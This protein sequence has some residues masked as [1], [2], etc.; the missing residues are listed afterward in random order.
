MFC[1]YTH[2]NIYIII[3][4]CWQQAYGVLLNLATTSCSWS[5]KRT[6]CHTIATATLVKVP[7]YD[8]PEWPE[9]C[10]ADTLLD[11]VALTPKVKTGETGRMPS[12]FKS[13][14]VSVHAIWS[15]HCRSSIWTLA[16][17]CCQGWTAT[18]LPQPLRPSE[19]TNMKL[20][21][22]AILRQNPSG[23]WPTSHSHTFQ[24]W[25]DPQTTRHGTSSAHHAWP[26]TCQTEWCCVPRW[27]HWAH[28]EANR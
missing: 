1:C 26:W 20:S 7:G 12:S 16:G 19:H 8:W 25:C 24:R 15:K 17:C 22:T 3:I 23:R 21:P 2:I 18:A 28:P 4:C 6:L 9:H 10:N 13:R 27:W 11:A 5:H 14:G